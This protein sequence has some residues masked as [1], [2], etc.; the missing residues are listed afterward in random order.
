MSAPQPPES[1][2]RVNVRVKKHKTQGQMLADF[3]E[4]VAAL[5]A[6]ERPALPPIP[7]GFIPH[8]GG[9]CPVAEG[10]TVLCAM[11]GGPH[12]K[13]NGLARWPCWDHKGFNDDIIAYRIERDPTFKVEAGRYYIDAEGKRHGPLCVAS[14]IDTDEP[15][16]YSAD[17]G[18]LWDEQGL[19]V[20]SCRDILCLAADQT[21]PMVSA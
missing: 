21:S 11:R 3:S 7:E 17:S 2:F 19:S 14:H 15:Y 5:R 1:I 18:D 13:A 4:A 12:L 9:P 10:V 6:E 20:N 16:F 8:D